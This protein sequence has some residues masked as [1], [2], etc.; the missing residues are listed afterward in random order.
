MMKRVITLRVIFDLPSGMTQAEAIHY[1]KDAI[2]VH[3]GGLHPDEPGFKL[4][5][6]NVRVAV[7]SVQTTYLK[8]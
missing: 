6:T 4:Q 3:G 2:M 5:G 7:H 1:V 8:D